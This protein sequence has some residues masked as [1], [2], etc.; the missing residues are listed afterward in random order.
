MDA[1]YGFVSTLLPG[2]TGS[3]RWVNTTATEFT[4]SPTTIVFNYQHQY[5]LIMLASPSSEGTVTP[6]SG[7]YNAGS[8][9]TIRATGIGDGYFDY[10]VGVGAGSYSGFSNPATITMNAAIVE[11]AKFSIS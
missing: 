5:I 1:G 6:E 7:W 4:V 8:T 3:E 9:V 2:S 10:W 11:E